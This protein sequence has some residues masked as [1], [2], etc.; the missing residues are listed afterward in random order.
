MKRVDPRLASQPYILPCNIYPFIIGTNIQAY[1]QARVN[2]KLTCL[3]HDNI[4]LPGSLA[5]E[6]E[7]IRALIVELFPFVEEGII[8]FGLR[9]SCNSFSDLA[10]QKYIS[11][12]SQNVLR[13]AELLDTTCKETLLFDATNTSSNYIM[14]LSAFL[15]HIHTKA[16]K[17]NI[18][19]TVESALETLA[20]TNGV[21]T[22][23]DA[24]KLIKNTYLDAQFKSVA[25]LLYSTIGAKMINSQA[26]IPSALWRNATSLSEDLS[27]ISLSK[28]P[29]Q[30]ADNAVMDYFTIDSNAIDKLSAKDLFELKKEPHTAKYIRELDQAVDEVT[31]LSDSDKNLD[32]AIIELANDRVREIKKAIYKRCQKEE[33]KLKVESY[34]FGAT[35]EAASILGGM[36]G[37]GPIKQGL[38]TLAR[39]IAKKSKKLE[40]L[41]Y[42]SAPLVSHVSRFRGFIKKHANA[43]L[44]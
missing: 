3:L 27:I 7:F 12:P 14:E 33:K 17:S 18:K 19:S 44:T 37:V 16:R 13:M 40:W 31:K 15:R 41:D 8:K 20:E 4:A 23:Q 2:L 21:F 26:I 24:L 6:S 32:T 9:S 38:T 34:V 30:I 11:Q 35:D 43:D 25:K 28:A 5:M 22:L 29:R 42:T 36:V 1:T 39:K 10:S